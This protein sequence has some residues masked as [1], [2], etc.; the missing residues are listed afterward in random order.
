MI[1]SRSRS[2]RSRTSP[3]GFRRTLIS[4]RP[5]L[6]TTRSPTVWSV[7]HRIRD[8]RAGI[9]LA[10]GPCT[11]TSWSNNRH[12]HALIDGHRIP[13]DG[14]SLT[15]RAR[16]CAVDGFSAVPLLRLLQP[17]RQFRYAYNPHSRHGVYL[18][19]RRQV[20]RQERAWSPHKTLLC[21]R[22]TYRFLS[23]VGCRATPIP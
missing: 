8:V 5:S 7:R 2:I 13:I 18:L 16:I 14:A 15:M 10:H 23:N 4:A 6:I 12:H 11:A 19:R 3:I 20:R 17:P 21:C 22:A 9:L 1:R